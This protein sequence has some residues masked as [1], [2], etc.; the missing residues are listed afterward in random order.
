M[1]TR[2]NTNCTR[3]VPRLVRNITL[4]EI[5]ASICYWR[6]QGKGYFDIR[7]APGEEQVIALE[8]LYM[9]LLAGRQGGVWAAHLSAR[10]YDALVGGARHTGHPSVATRL[11]HR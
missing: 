11:S 5:E 7:P 9:R 6:G 8:Q 2:S 3:T 4:A 10:E 1:T